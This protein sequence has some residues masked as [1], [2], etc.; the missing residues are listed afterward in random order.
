M[1]TPGTDLVR[2]VHSPLPAL[3]LP[4]TQAE[5]SARLLAQKRRPRALGLRTSR[6]L[7]GAKR[8][9]PYAPGG[10]VGGAHGSTA[11]GRGSPVGPKRSG[12]CLPCRSPATA[13]DGTRAAARR[14]ARPRVGLSAGLNLLRM[15]ASP[16]CKSVINCS[17][18]QLRSSPFK[19]RA[20]LRPFDHTPM[21]TEES[22]K[23][24][25]RR[26]CSWGFAAKWRTSVRNGRPSL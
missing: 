18:T 20:L 13:A 8:K 24:M 2:Q 15:C 12:T 6:G 1:A 25:W 10:R 9:R 7:R 19:A 3:S 16:I 21:L 5:S 11:S 14:T 17:G 22:T 23:A 26:P 4:P